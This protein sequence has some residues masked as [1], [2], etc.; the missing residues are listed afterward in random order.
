MKE[1]TSSKINLGIL[2]SRM[3]TKS[4]LISLYPRLSDR[5]QNYND[6]VYS[7]VPYEAGT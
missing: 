3:S 2:E 6:I 1:E 4:S 5:R 7:A